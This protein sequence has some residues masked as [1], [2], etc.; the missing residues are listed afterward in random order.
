M[1]ILV[2]ICCAPCFIA[3]YFHLK[4]EGF[5]IHGFW[6]NPNI[7]PYQEYQKR[8]ETLQE[9]TEKEDIRMIYKDEYNLD[10]F[11]QKTAFRENERCGSCYYDRLK[12]AAIVAKKGNFDLFTT[13]LL[14]SKFQKHDMIREIGESLGEEYGIKFFYRDFRQYWKEGIRLSKELGMYRQQYCGCIYSERDRYLGKN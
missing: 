5:D 6:F 10:D 14:Y 13:T 2:H 1:K 4:Q 12:Y 3:P 11:L 8:L 9:L 7:H